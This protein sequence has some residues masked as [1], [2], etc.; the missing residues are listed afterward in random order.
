MEK[1]RI[2]ITI[3]EDYSYEVEYTTGTRAPAVTHKGRSNQALV[4]TDIASAVRNVVEFLQNSIPMKVTECAE[5]G[6][7]DG[8]G[9]GRKCHS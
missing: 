5:W 3:E 6:D 4:A 8:R 2:H 9:G 7:G 1:I